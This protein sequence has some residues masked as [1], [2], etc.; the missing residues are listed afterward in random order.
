MTYG[1]KRA[2]LQ[3]GALSIFETCMKFSLKLEL[4]WIPRS[5]NDKADYI[6][7]IV[8]YDDWRI[9]PVIFVQLD[10]LWG[11]HTVDCFASFY[12]KQMERYFSRFW[13]PGTEAVDAFTVS[14]NDEVCWWVPPLYLVSRVIKHA[15]ACAAMGTL[16]VPAWRSAPFWP[17]LCT[18][19]VRFAGFVRR[20]TKFKYHDYLIRDGRSGNNIGSA[21]NT[22]TDILAIFIDFASK[23]RLFKAGFCT[24][25]SCSAC[26]LSWSAAT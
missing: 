8:D 18:D 4:E 13:N 22:D 15:K 16:I 11:P 9:D 21:M 5:Q 3:D 19:G 1:S 7:R 2:H 24:F 10:T 20:W 26:S 6:S 23:P 14:W 12:N 17:M 25:D